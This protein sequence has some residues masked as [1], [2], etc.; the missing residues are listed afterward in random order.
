MWEG[1]IQHKNHITSLLRLLR[2]QE[3]RQES[4]LSGRDGAACRGAGHLAHPGERSLADLLQCSTETCGPQNV[5][6]CQPDESCLLSISEEAKDG[7]VERYIQRSCMANC[8]DTSLKLGTIY[9][10]QRCCGTDLCNL[11]PDVRRPSRTLECHGC[12]EFGNDMQCLRN[13]TVR[14]EDKQTQCA[15]I[16]TRLPG[17]KL[18]EVTLRA[19]VSTSWCHG[20]KT[21]ASIFAIDNIDCCQHSLCN[22][23]AS[24][25]YRPLRLLLPPTCLLLMSTIPIAGWW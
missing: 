24:P 5:R 25:T 20:A 16:H 4:L 7:V 9:L 21:M 3:R 15:E 1:W 10:D 13:G 17:D 2:A 12:L 14:C 22:R 8:T 11:K 18:R 6:Q 23:A 19:C